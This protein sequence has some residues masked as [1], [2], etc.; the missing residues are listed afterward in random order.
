MPH[1]VPASGLHPLERRVFRC[2]AGAIALTL[3][4]AACTDPWSANY[5]G[6]RLASLAPDAQVLVQS[7]PS[8]EVMLATPDGD[9]QFLGESSFSQSTVAS[10]DDIEPFARSIGASRVLWNIGEPSFDEHFSTY[11]AP[12]TDTTR[13]QGTVR[14]ADGTMRQIDLTSKTSR[15]EDRTVQEQQR[16]YPHRAVFLA[17]IP[18]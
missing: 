10:T 12:V 1:H 5:R 6:S 11:H 13:T 3:L 9:W 2:P 17:R 8:H 15:W 16:S 7:A 14:G 4:L 18:R